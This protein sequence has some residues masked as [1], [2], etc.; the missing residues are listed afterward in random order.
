[1]GMPL[2]FAGIWSA[3]K[4]LDKWRFWPSG[5][6]RCKVRGPPTSVGFILWG[7]WAY[8]P[9]FMAIHPIVEIFQSEPKWWTDQQTDVASTTATLLAWLKIQAVF[10]AGRRHFQYYEQKKTLLLSFFDQVCSYKMSYNSCARVNKL[11]MQLMESCQTRRQNWRED[12]VLA[13]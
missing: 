11:F 3:T 2:V 7:A 10:E 9:N 8:V 13:E 1:M 12:F 5:G 4:V 6:A